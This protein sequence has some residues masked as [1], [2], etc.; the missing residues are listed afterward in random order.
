[1]LFGKSISRV[2]CVSCPYEYAEFAVLLISLAMLV[3]LAFVIA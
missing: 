2:N 3:T 1:M